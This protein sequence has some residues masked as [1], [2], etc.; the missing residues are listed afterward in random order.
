MQKFKKIYVEITN[1]CNLKCSFCGGTKKKEEFMDIRFFGKILEKIK[2]RAPHLCLHVM[3]EPLMH[4]E[5]GALMDLCEKY[6]FKVNLATNGTMMNELKNIMHKPA[7]RQVSFS[8]HSSDEAAD[9]ESMERYAAP[10]FDFAGEAAA[11]GVLISLRLWNLREDEAE[12]NSNI[13]GMIEKKYPQAAPVDKKETRV[14]GINLAKNIFLSQAERFVW[15]ALEAPETGGRAFCL[16][17]RDQIAVLAD[18][19][20]VP[21]CLDANGIMA[22]GNIREKGFEEILTG[23]RARKIYDGFSAKKAV[24]PLCA[25]CGYRSRFRRKAEM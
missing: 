14:N 24:E 19:T 8:L 2:G 13:I 4:P 22:L 12:L 20:V 18:G 10:V 5:I 15:P 21:C 11:A 25:K 6:S 17:L 9:K 16:G 3:G 7:L 1:V 23:K